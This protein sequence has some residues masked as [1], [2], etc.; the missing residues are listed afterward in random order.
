MLSK[1]LKNHQI[2]KLYLVLIDIGHVFYIDDY[3]SMWQLLEDSYAI[4]LCF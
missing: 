2:L 4:H 3:F 1:K